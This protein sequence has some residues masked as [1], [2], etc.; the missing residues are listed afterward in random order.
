MGLFDGLTKEGRQ[1]AAIERA[2]K[3][4]ANKFAQHEDRFAAMEKLRDAGTA[5]D[6]ALAEGA[7]HAL[8][9]RFSYVY[10][11]AIQDEQE[12]EWAENA[13]VGL[14][15]AAIEPLRKHALS[16]QTLSYVMKV[17]GRIADVPTMLAILDDLFAKEEPGYTRDP[18]RKIQILTFVLEWEGAPAAE[19]AK[20]VAPYVTDF[21]ENVRFNAIQV[22]E[23]HRDVVAAP[24]AVA[25]LVRKEEE[26]RR[27]KNRL[28]E[29]IADAGWPLGER[30]AEVAALG[31][32]T[33]SV[34]GDKLIRAGAK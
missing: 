18:Q 13:L 25:A 2:A 33:V 1:K 17:L 12:K 27:I 32:T 22:L 31:L 26:S 9:H 7:I 30:A 15:K 20:R 24:A 34:D 21:D 8:A 29:L 5:S 14:G 10:D 4:V 23:A 6:S 11:K 16:A 19:V 3:T 28:A